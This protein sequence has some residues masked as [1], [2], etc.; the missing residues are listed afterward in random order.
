MKSTSAA[1]VIIHA[2][3]PGPGPPMFE[4]IGAPA[5][6][7]RAELF[8]SASKSAT[9]CPSDGGAEGDGD[10][11]ACSEQENAMTAI[12]KKTRIIT[13]ARYSCADFSRQGKWHCA[14]NAYP[15]LAASSVR[16]CQRVGDNAFHL[17][18]VD[19]LLLKTMP[20]QAPEAQDNVRGYNAP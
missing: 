5:S 18:K 7:P 19:R 15:R 12:S 4:A 11:C 3:W 1:Q 8:T 14:S 2:L 9:R 20:R 17:S 16:S 13:R 10:V 6:A